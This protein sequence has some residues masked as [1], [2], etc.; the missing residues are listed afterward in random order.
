[1]E[2]NGKAWNW[3]LVGSYYLS[4]EFRADLG[5][6]DKLL[7]LEHDQCNSA[8]YREYYWGHK[9]EVSGADN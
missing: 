5:R 8:R 9:V 3:T 4:F 1:M 6:S 7:L 2:E